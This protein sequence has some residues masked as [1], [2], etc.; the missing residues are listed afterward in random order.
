MKEIDGKVAFITGGASGIGLAIAKVL[1]GAGARVAIAD[2]RRDHL[3]EAAEEMRGSGLDVHPI[4]LDVADRDA[5]EAAASEMEQVFGK[6]H[7]LCNVAGVNIIRPM[8]EASYEDIDWLMDVNL[9]GTFNSLMS[10]IPRIKAH[11]EGG[12][13]INTSSVAG[14]ITGP[15]TGI[16]SATKFAI[17]GLSDALRFDMA[18]HGIAVSILCPG[19][20]STR[21]YE[22]EDNR[23]D[24]FQGEVNESVTAL[25]A[26]TGELFRK[27]LPLGMDAME[28]AEK[29]LKGIR[30]NAFYIMTHVEVEQDIREAYEDMLDALP[31]EPPDPDRVELEEGR[32][33]KKYELL[34]TLKNL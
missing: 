10:F 21:L 23:P 32:R 20:V 6:V 19:T 16:Y 31:D 4:L 5:M 1:A 7:L 25:R 11:G 29:T 18:P 34:E 3:D 22:S 15:G 26:G 17:R 30:E 28:V 24:R 2:L 14:I 13:I 12:H 27:V 9:G 8:D 33:Q